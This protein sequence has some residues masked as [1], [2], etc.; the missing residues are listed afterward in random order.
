GESRESP[1][2]TRLA[3]RYKATLGRV[4]GAPRAV[5]IGAGAAVLIAAL[6]FVLQDMS[7]VPTFKDRDVLVQ[8][9]APPGTSNPRMTQITTDLSR[10]LR[11]IPGV[12]NVGGHVGRAV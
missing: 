8:L 5:A 7:A 6:A 2:L 11:S 1:L 3:P 12:D 10:K 9:D 4:T